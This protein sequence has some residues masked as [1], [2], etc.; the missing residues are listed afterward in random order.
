MRTSTRPAVSVAWTL[1]AL[2]ATA[3]VAAAR[4][5]AE[6]QLPAGARVGVVNLLDAEVTHYH[7]ARRLQNSF[8]KTYPVDWPVSALLLEA[9][10]QRLKELGLVAVP[11]GPSSEL[12]RARETC[13][14]NAELAKGLP[15]PC[16]APFAAFAAAQGVSALIVLGPGRNDA[17]H[18]GS[19]RQRGLPEYLRGW[20]LV[21][22]EGASGAAPLLLDLTELLLIGVGPGGAQLF[23]REWGGEDR[24]WSGFAPSTDGTAISTQQLAQ[25]Q[26]V[27]A[28]RLQQRAGALLGHLRV[29]R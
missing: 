25:L 7:A 28:A 14:L 17:A 8:L 4:P 24:S 16:A 20:C 15:K 12:S 22:G 3:D 19:A 2:L 26:P 18:A 21:S 9:L 27:F 13:F 29:A 5:P 11:A 1:C 6:L 10:G 23:D